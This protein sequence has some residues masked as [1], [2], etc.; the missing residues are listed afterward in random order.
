MRRLTLSIGF[1]QDRPFLFLY[2]HTW[3]WATSEK[4]AGFVPYPDGII[5]LKGTSLPLPGVNKQ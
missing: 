5:R 4:L 3:F 1:R 2:H